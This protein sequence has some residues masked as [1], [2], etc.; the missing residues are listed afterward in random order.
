MYTSDRCG[1]SNLEVEGQGLMFAL[2]GSGLALV[3]SF[4]SVALFLLYGMG[5]FTLC[6]GSMKLSF[7]F[8]R[9]S[10]LGVGLESQKRFGRLRS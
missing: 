3:L 7:L 4:L 8:Y 1:C 9:G 5:M 10:Q 6:S 2:L